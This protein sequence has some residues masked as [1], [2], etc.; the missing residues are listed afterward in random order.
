MRGDFWAENILAYI[1]LA[2]LFLLRHNLVLGMSHVVEFVWDDNVFGKVVEL[3]WVK[4]GRQRQVW[5]A[6]IENAPV[7]E[8]EE[9]TLVLQNLR[10]KLLEAIEKHSA[11]LWVEL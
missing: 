9:T 7:K 6:P 2:D 5:S 3:L 8:W 11:H 4:I 1:N 10:S